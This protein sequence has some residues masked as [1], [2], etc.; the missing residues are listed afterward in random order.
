MGQLSRGQRST[1]GGRAL[2]MHVGKGARSNTDHRSC[3]WFA[4]RVFS[5][6][7]LSFKLWL[8]WA[9]SITFKA[10]TEAPVSRAFCQHISIV[11]SVN[12]PG[13]FPQ[14]TTHTQ[15]LI[16]PVRNASHSQI[17]RSPHHNNPIIRNLTRVRFAKPSI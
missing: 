2:A 11:K 16:K 3:L 8:G 13:T 7:R 17:I 14:Y 15:S 4:I 10:S 12:R 5:S 6:E 9:T 1:Y